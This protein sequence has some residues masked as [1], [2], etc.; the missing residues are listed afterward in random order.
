MSIVWANWRMAVSRKLWVC[1]A[2]VAVMSALWLMVAWA[3]GAH[4][5]HSWFLGPALMWMPALFW[6]VMA[7]WRSQ[8]RLT[9]KPL[10]F[11]WPGFRESLRRLSFI[12]VVPAG[13]LGALFLLVT[14]PFD[15][16]LALRQMLPRELDILKAAD[17][18]S[19]FLACS[20]QFGCSVP[21]EA[22]LRVAAGFTASAAI[23]LWLL[24]APLVFSR[25]SRLVVG[26]SF[27][28]LYLVAPL[29]LVAGLCFPLLIWPTVFLVGAG[30]AAFIWIR[31]GDVTRVA[32]GHRVIIAE[33]GKR[34][35]LG[36]RRT[37]GISIER[38]FRLAMERCDD[39][40]GRR[41]L[42]GS[43][44]CALGP[45]LAAWKRHGVG[46]LVM[47]LVAG[48]YRWIAGVAI[49]VVFAWVVTRIDLPTAS[50]L[51][52]PAGRRERCHATAVITLGASLLLALAAMCLVLLSRSVA[53]FM[54]HGREF[55]YVTFDIGAVFLPSLLVPWLVGFELLAYAKPG[56]MRTSLRA[57][58]SLL[59][60]L[61][62]VLDSPLVR[63]LETPRSLPFA[64]VFIC[65]WVFFL[66]VL[67]YVC[68]K[69]SLVRQRVRA[70]G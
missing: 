67:R 69:G 37:V 5:W 68:T 63:W 4:A 47:A 48:Y 21:V 17:G 66:F 57:G 16:S 23:A 54:P 60:I 14:F 44:F 10:S 11:S 49:F 59:L 58:V 24:V 30:A 56:V 32:Q 53:P 35:R 70:G 28:L 7:A 50:S 2:V 12:G 22:C 38:P 51:L 42:W 18:H 39:V 55:E 45:M 33:A 34:E 43:L 9:S 36:S 27:G 13:L 61:F 46:L 26:V 41:H 6:L 52:L 31:L 1:L 29:T 62:I 65:G 8:Q 3:A 25:C 19:L 40:S 15:L 20:H 64:G